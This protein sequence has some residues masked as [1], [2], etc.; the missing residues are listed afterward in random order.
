ME[1]DRQKMSTDYLYKKGVE[2][3]NGDVT[4]VRTPLSDRPT[5]RNLK[6]QKTLKNS[7]TVA[8]RKAQ[9]MIAKEPPWVGLSNSDTISGRWLHLLPII[10]YGPFFRPKCANSL[11]TVRAGRGMSTEHE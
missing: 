11:K 1:R 5:S 3:S 6:N 7:P 2:E 4:S 10:A 9:H 8:N